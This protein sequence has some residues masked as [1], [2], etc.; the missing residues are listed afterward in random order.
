L[1]KEDQ[2][3]YFTTFTLTVWDDFYAGPN[4][5]ID[6][7]IHDPEVDQ[8]AHEMSFLIS[9]YETVKRQPARL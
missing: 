2:L 6:W 1:S 4:G 9:S 8:A 5:E 3:R 7:F